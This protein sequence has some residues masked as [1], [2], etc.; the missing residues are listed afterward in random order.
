MARS[1]KAIMACARWLTYCL[2]IGWTHDDLD[3]LDAIWWEW[4]DDHGRLI[5]RDHQ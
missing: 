2:S 5:S 1:Q 3:A 4:H